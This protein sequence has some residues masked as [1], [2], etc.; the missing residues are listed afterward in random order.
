MVGENAVQPDRFIQLLTQH[1]SQLLGYIAASVGNY[2]SA[3]DILQ[4]TNM[5]LWNKID[6]FSPDAEFLPWAMAFARYE[7]LAYY[8]DHQRDPHVFRPDVGEMMSDAAAAEIHDI[9][10]RRRA[11]REC[12]NQLS[13]ANRKLLDLRYVNNLSISQL[14]EQTGRSVDGIKSLMLRIRKSLRECVGRGLKRQLEN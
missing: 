9:P 14:S 12:L 2:S 3:Q 5:A 7:V 4:R 1:Q 10:A 8:R 6:E 11:L 13:E